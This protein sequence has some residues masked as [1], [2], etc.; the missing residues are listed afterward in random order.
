MSCPKC[1]SDDLR[2]LVESFWIDL[3]E[4]GDPVI[5]NGSV[6]D[7]QSESYLSER[8]LCCNCEHEFDDGD[9]PEKEGA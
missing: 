8:R 1:G 4:K 2:G 7:W 6:A 3:D 9:E 5:R